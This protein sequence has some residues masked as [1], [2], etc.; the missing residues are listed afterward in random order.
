MQ[1]IHLGDIKISR[2]TESEGPT[3]P[4]FLLPG[5]TEEILR[6]NA[7]W[8]APHFY[9][10]A[11]G[12]LMMSI[13]SFIVRTRHH[14]ILVDTCLGNGKKRGVPNWHMRNGPFLQDLKGAGVS[15]EEVDFVMCTHL[16][17]DHVGWNT[18]LDNG[19][20]VPTFPN[21][22]YLFARTEWEHWSQAQDEESRE[23]MRDS[24]IPVIE[25][26]Q[27][28]LVESNHAID[29][30]LVFE[31]T[32]GHTPGHVSLHMSS[33]GQEAVITG[34]MIH[35]PIQCAVPEV[36]SSF[37]VNEKQAVATRREFLATLRGWARAHSGNA[38][39]G[40]RCRVCGE[41]G[42]RM[43]RQNSAGIGKT[44]VGMHTYPA[45]ARFSGG[46]EMGLPRG[47]PWG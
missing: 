45:L 15:A 41:R 9:D 30:E 29:D 34:D 40:P 35:H 43:A 42:R 20:W 44:A 16:H 19:R 26:R 24:V 32:P 18:R 8:M 6:T 1:P 22:R 14:T 11:T 36:C 39:R 47:R 46:S 3:P 12:M 37:C 21:A 10:P 5:A 31:P 33:K 17:V 38:F 27:A 28:D 2:V 7:E 13:H 23:I 4:G 25:A